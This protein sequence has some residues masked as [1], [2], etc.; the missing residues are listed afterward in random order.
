M[1]DETGDLDEWIEQFLREE[2]AA[3]KEMNMLTEGTRVIL[4]TPDPKL[5]GK[6]GIVTQ[7][8]SNGQALVRFDEDGRQYAV[9]VSR[10]EREAD[11]PDYP[12]PQEVQA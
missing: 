2:E 11:F 1:F 9:G 3:K 10:L 12:L 5:D 4:T 6:R 8:E 7:S